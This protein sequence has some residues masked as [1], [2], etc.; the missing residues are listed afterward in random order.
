M[1]WGDFY[2][3]ELERMCYKT[4]QVSMQRGVKKYSEDRKLS[5]MKEMK[6][7]AIKNDC[8]DELE[9]SS[10]IDEMKKRALPL[11]IFIA[12]KGNS[13]L[14]WR[15][16]AN[17]S[18]QQVCTDKTKV[19]LR[20]PDFYSLKYSC[21]VAAKEGRDIGIVDLPGFFL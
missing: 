4:K 17:E 7:L 18:F 20:T 15:G 16:V 9:Y 8:F 21:V 13:T 12:I 5:V 2:A 3:F 1:R 11:L 6:N 14:K 10:M 19:L